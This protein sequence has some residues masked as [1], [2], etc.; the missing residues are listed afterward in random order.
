MDSD[1]V[2]SSQ[3]EMLSVKGKAVVI[4]YYPEEYQ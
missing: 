4:N 1:S 3:S 2:T